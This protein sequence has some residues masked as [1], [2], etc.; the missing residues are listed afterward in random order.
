[1]QNSNLRNRITRAEF[2]A[3]AVNFYSKISK[4]NISTKENP[5][6]D[7]SKTSYTTDIIKAYSLGIVSGVSDN[8]FNPDGEITREQAATMLMRTA[9][10]S[11]YNTSYSTTVESGIS[12]WAIKGVGF[13][14]E[15]GIMNGTGNGFEPQGKYTREQAV[16]TF[17]RMYDNL[18]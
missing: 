16:I 11:E 6:N 5:F 9:E 4:N 8:E 17:V 3:M 14:T 1:M 7:I 18:K 10:A 13:V 2:A 15:K 12:S